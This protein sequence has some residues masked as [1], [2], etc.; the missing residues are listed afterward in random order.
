MGGSPSERGPSELG[1]EDSPSWDRGRGREGANT[2]REGRKWNPW[3]HGW[4]GHVQ[5]AKQSNKRRAVSAQ[6]T[7]STPPQTNGKRPNG[8]GA[9]VHDNANPWLNPKCPSSPT[10]RNAESKNHPTPERT[11]TH[12]VRSTRFHT[13]RRR[14]ALGLQGRRTDPSVAVSTAPHEPT[15]WP[16]W[17]LPCP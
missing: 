1:R 6:S 14:E 12:N 3:I 5:I 13:Y 16:A 9:W 2:W 15:A 10:C 4:M 8:T 7:T 11:R 17:T